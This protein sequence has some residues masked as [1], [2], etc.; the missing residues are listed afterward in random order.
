MRISNYINTQGMIIGAILPKSPEGQNSRC[1]RNNSICFGIVLNTYLLAL[2]PCT[3]APYRFESKITQS[4]C[5]PLPTWLY[6]TGRLEKLH[7]FSKSWELNVG[8]QRRIST[9]FTT[10]YTYP[11][12]FLTGSFFQDFSSNQLMQTYIFPQSDQKHHPVTYTKQHRLMKG[13]NISCIYVIVS[14]RGNNKE[15]K[16]PCALFPSWKNQAFGS[17]LNMIWSICP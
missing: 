14:T 5:Y 12:H 13:G 17:S 15:Q 8:R 16:F 1:A 2:T 4:N 11:Y 10:K 9:A 3:G 6:Q 7:Q